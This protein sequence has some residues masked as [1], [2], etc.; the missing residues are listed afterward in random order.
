MANRFMSV[1]DAEG[2]DDGPRP[3]RHC[4]DVEIGPARQEHHLRWHGRAIAVGELAEEGQIE[5]GETVAANRPA[6][7]Q[8]RLTGPA[9]VGRSGG[10]PT[11]LESKISFDGY[12]EIAGAAGIVVP[13]A[14][15]QLLPGQ[16]A[17]GF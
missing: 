10:V 16:I 5:F 2:N 12:A 8:N 6:Q 3:T 1:E 17:G 7:A 13:A 11:Q 4:I 9:H 14:L 15:S